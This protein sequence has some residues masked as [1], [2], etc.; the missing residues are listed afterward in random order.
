MK[1]ICSLIFVISLVSFHFVYPYIIFLFSLNLSLRYVLFKVILILNHIDFY[2]S[3]E[4][5]ENKPMDVLKL[6]YF[7]IILSWS[8]AWLNLSNEGVDVINLYI[9]I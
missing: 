3:G 6:H 7:E 1:E 5:P 4:R 9:F 2:I 8:F